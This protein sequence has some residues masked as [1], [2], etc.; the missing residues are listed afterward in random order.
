MHRINAIMSIQEW[1]EHKDTID[2]LALFFRTVSISRLRLTILARMN[3][4]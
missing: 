1:L 3:M 2:Y 4:L